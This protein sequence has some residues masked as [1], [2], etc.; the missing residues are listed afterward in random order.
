[1]VLVN[2]VSAESGI[3]FAGFYKNLFSV[4]DVAN[5]YRNLGVTDNDFAVDDL[6]RL[7][8]KLDYEPHEQWSMRVHF[9]L[10]SLWGE[11]ERIR[12]RMAELPVALPFASAKARPRFLD[13]E[14]AW[15]EEDSFRLEHGLDR[16]QLRYQS[17]TVEWTLG[18]QAVSWGSGLIWTP[19]DLF[20]GFSPTEIDRDEKTGVDVVR[21]IWSPTP[22]ASIDLI[23]EPLGDKAYEL[24]TDASS[25][26]ARGTTHIGEYDVALLGGVIAG[27]TVV[28]GDFTG[29]LRDAGFR[30]EWIYTWV[31]EA[32]QRDYLRGLL[33]VDY[34]FARPWN[35]Y[36]ALEYFYNGLGAGHADDY[37]TRLAES[38]VQRAFQR[39]TAFNFGQHYLGSTLRVAP[40]ALLA[41]SAT[42][43]LNL[44]DGSA[45]EFVG[46]VWSVTDNVDLLIGATV[47]IGGLGTEF[48]GFSA[49]QAGADFENPDL[50][51]AFLKYYF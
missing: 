10:R 15:I 25:L 30:G 43:L 23:A 29:Y 39:G 22:D 28:G 21:F 35:P 50:Y 13:L 11:T 34:G 5:N 51:Y 42:T 12:N 7:R 32:D 2:V 38:S 6:Q 3:E 14:S 48:G 36:L 16:L 37:L 9:E 40:S 26:A 24:E 18:R 27:D 47:G 41:L 44:M 17:D 8:L 4:T 49:E 20:V 33:S 46:A 19:T 31:D 1:M 45:V